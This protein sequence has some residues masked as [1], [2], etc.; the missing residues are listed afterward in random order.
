[1]KWQWQAPEAR[2]IAVAVTATLLGVGIAWLM[3]FDP[4]RRIP[5]GG[6]LAKSATAIAVAA[7]AAT[8]VL[9]NSLSER[10]IKMQRDLLEAFLE[11]I[12]INV[13]FKDREG[14]FIR[15][16]RSMADYFGLADP[17]LALGKCDSDIFSSEHAVQ[18]L[19]DEQEVIRTGQPMKGSEEKETWPDGHETWVLTTKVPLKNHRGH[20]VGTMGVSQ[21]ISDR[22][23]AEERVQHMALH[24]PLTGLPNRTLLQD[25]L[26]EAIARGRCCQACVA[27]LMLDLDQFKNVND[28]L[29]H[30]AGDR[31]LEAVSMRL[32]GC[33]RDSDMVARLGGDEF[34]IALQAVDDCEEIEELA[35]RV[36]TKLN[37]PFQ[38]DGHSLRVGASLGISQFPA[39]G[40]SSEELLQA[41]DVAMYGAKAT[42]RGVYIFSRP[43]LTP[44]SSAEQNL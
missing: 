24:D 42:G 5:L 19:R 38:I 32:M 7:L 4:V 27:V 40:E 43:L 28:S 31:L 23:R 29:G 21:D 17:S 16:S 10:Q 3:P 26:T 6:F 11:H 35:R 20:I 44:A 37:D 9:L 41:A 22:K 12:P 1:M 14:R 33:I 2:G 25:W 18:A 30:R 15:I 13:F 34:V 39:D 8:V 36:L